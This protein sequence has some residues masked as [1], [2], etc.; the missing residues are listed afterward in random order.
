MSAYRDSSEILGDCNLLMS[1]EVKAIIN[2]QGFIHKLGQEFVTELIKNQIELTALVQTT[3]RTALI[4]EVDLTKNT[5][6]PGY[7]VLTHT[8]DE[9]TNETIDTFNK[10]LESIARTEKVGGQEAQQSPVDEEVAGKILKKLM[11]RYH[12][13]KGGPGTIRL[14][15]GL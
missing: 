11:N 8:N 4:E 7:T 2:T 5:T 10:Y 14:G 15:S 12:L 13:D 3:P 6:K 1:S 9:N